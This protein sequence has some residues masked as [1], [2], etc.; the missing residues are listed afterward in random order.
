MVLASPPARVRMVSAPTAWDP[1]QR[2]SAANAGGYNTALIATP[3]SSQAATNQPRVGAAAI[4]T[5]AATATRE[6]RV[7][8]HRGPCRSSHRPTT[9]PSSAETTSPAENA[10]ASADGAQPVSALIRP[11]STGNA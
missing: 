3:A 6:P 8:S 7:I 10:A 5:T 9:T 1:Y 11:D 4:A 2:V